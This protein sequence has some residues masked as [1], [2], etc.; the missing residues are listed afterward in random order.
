MKCIG[1]LLMLVVLTTG[2]AWGH[3]KVLSLDGDGDYIEIPDGVWFDD[4]LTFEAWVFIRKHTNSSVVMEFGGSDQGRV[5]FVIENGEFGLPVFFVNEEIK[6]QAIASGI[7]IELNS[8]VHLAYILNGNSATIYINGTE[9]GSGNIDILPNNVT[10]KSNF[11]GRSIG[12]WADANAM[13][14]EIRIWNIAKS[15]AEIQSKIN[16]SL[17]GDESGLVGYWNF[18]DGTA[19]D[20]TSNENDGEM[21]GDAQI[22]NLNDLPVSISPFEC[23]SIGKSSKYRYLG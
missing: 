8:W 1:L 20:L 21:K 9:V 13:Y 14:D 2:L 23:C 18:D 12:A 6:W 22:V 3:N 7:Y 16:S 15:T 19:K 11:I 5:G 10:R 4:D 17:S